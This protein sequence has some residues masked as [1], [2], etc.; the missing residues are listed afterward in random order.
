MKHGERKEIA[1]MFNV[2]EVT[3]RNALKGRTQSELSRRIRR[4]AIQ[5]GGIEVDDSKSM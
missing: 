4:M 3:V 5:R 2:S 1:K